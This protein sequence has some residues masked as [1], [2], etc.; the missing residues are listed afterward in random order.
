M[1]LLFVLMLFLIL[2]GL[3]LLAAG[4]AIRVNTALETKRVSGVLAT[5]AEKIEA[6]E[7]RVLIQRADASGQALK[8]ILARMNLAGRMEN[9]LR[10]AGLDWSLEKLVLFMLVMAA[11]GV[12]IGMNA[13]LLLS[14]TLT[15]LALGCFTGFVP[16]FY[17]SRT[18]ARRLA[19]FEAEFPEAL[20]FLARSL[21]SGHALTVSFE[22]LATEAPEPVRTEFARVYNE[23]NLGESLNVVL[24][25][26]ADRIP[27]VDVRFFVSAVLMQRE[28]GGNLGEIL[29]K[30][31]LVIR[32]RFRVKGQV[33]A[34]SAHGRITAA[35]LTVM[36]LVS[37]M[38]LTLIAPTYLPSMMRD[39]DGKY[40]IFGAVLSQVIGFLVMRKIVNIKV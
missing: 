29:T 2:L 12:L 40:L 18:R 27:L 13:P 37:A 36:P 24:A 11:I 21:R 16:W 3:T 31:S 39:P 20:D 10:Q 7:V 32:E 1:S 4:I 9:R 17:V 30:L 28:T 22:L 14:P 19:R 35:I 5:L 25:H 26:L 38:G 34:A 8:R 15:A 6:P 23:Q 33:R